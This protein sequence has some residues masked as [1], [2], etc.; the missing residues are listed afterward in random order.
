MN[1]VPEGPS[2]ADT[3]APV[4]NIPALTSVGDAPAAKE[5][6]LKHITSSVPTPLSIDFTGDCEFPS[7]VSLQLALAASASLTTMGRMA[8]YGVNATNH[9]RKIGFLK[10]AE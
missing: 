7:V 5:M 1:T 8:G 3:C 6:L 2:I 10:V 9:L 4:L